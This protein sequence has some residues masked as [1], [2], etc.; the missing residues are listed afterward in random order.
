MPGNDYQSQMPTRDALA[1]ANQGQTTEYA[2]DHDQVLQ[3]TIEM[4]SIQ[5]EKPNKCY[6]TQSQHEQSLPDMQWLSIPY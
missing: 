3:D 5:P 1:N 4:F 6:R 2:K